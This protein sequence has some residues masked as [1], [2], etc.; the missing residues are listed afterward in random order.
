M[1][2]RQ[3]ETVIQYAGNK[4]PRNEVGYDETAMLSRTFHQLEKP[5][6]LTTFHKHVCVCTDETLLSDGFVPWPTLWHGGSTEVLSVNNFWYKPNKLSI[7]Q[8]EFA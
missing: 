8:F 5:I 3:P 6:F 2:F 7:E 4:A 1:D